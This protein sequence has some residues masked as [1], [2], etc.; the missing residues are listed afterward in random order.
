MITKEKGR[1]KINK[2]RN[3]VLLESKTTYEHLLLK[4][5][6]PNKMIE[7]QSPGSRDARGEENL[8]KG[9][10]TTCQ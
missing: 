3:A 6:E 4:R 10:R 5:L 8:K 1:H 9:S 7:K 2:R